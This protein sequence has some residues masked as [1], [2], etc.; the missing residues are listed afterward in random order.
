MATTEIYGS[1]TTPSK[2]DT[3]RMLWCKAVRAQGGT[4]LQSDTVR[5]LEVKLDKTYKSM[6]SNNNGS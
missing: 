4:P 5:M 3:K 1:G 2:G 6:A